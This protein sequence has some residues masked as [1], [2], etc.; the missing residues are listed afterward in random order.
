MIAGHV[1]VQ[2]SFSETVFL[3]K[4]EGRHKRCVYRI[5]DP[6]PNII[7]I[8]VNSVHSRDERPDERQEENALWIGKESI[9]QTVSEV[10]I[11]LPHCYLIMFI[12][13]TESCLVSSFIYILYIYGMIQNKREKIK[14]DIRDAPLNN[15]R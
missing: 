4:F 1:L 10:F 13:G 11:Y 14:Q 8:K 5:L 3:T 15:L 7:T 9:S 6:F 12:L 2:R